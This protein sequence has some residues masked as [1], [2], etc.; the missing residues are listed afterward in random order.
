ML[1]AA[2]NVVAA[3]RQ[4]DRWRARR[5][6]Q[7]RRDFVLFLVLQIAGI[8]ANGII[9]PATYAVYIVDRLVGSRLEIRGGCNRQ[10]AARR[11]AH[12][13]DPLRTESPLLGPAAH[14]AH[15]PLGILQRAPRRLSLGFIRSPRHAI[16]DN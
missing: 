8:N 16:L 1:R 9:R 4:E 14:Q 15:R 3:V 10:M 2:D 5:N 6:A 12:Q 11:K 13:A 7:T